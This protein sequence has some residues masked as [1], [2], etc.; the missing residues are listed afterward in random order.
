[1]AKSNASID[2]WKQLLKQ[3]VTFTGLKRFVSTASMRRSA[4]RVLERQDKYLVIDTSGIDSLKEEVSI[5]RLKVV[6]L[7]D[8][9]QASSSR[10]GPTI[11]STPEPTN[12]ANPEKNTTLTNTRT[13]ILK[14]TWSGR[15]ISPPLR[16]ADITHSVGVVD[17][18]A[19][20]A[21][22]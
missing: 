6:F 17:N 5:D 9:R 4:F 11:A 8:K 7:D 12:A 3:T 1:M 21:A 10:Q 13:S 15:T 20:Q 2:N 16:F 22:L 14:K 18:R 19:S